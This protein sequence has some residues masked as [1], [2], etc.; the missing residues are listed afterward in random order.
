MFQPIFGSFDSYFIKITDIKNSSDLDFDNKKLKNYYT[1]S[2]IKGFLKIRCKAPLMLRHLFL[3]NKIFSNNQL[4]SGRKYYLDLNDKKSY[5]FDKNLVGK[6]L[7]IKITIFGLE[8]N[9]KIKF[10][11]NK[12]TYNLT[13]KPFELN[14]TYNNYSENLFTFE[15]IDDNI[16]NIIIAEINVGILPE[17]INKTFRH[18]DFI[19]SFGSLKIN[20]GERVI[21]KI[22]NNLTN[23]LFDF[24]IIFEG[25]ISSNSIYVDISYDKLEFQTMCE[26]S[27][28]SAPPSVPLFMVN[29]YDYVGNNLLE[30]NN[31]FFYILLNTNFV[32]STI[33]IRKP[34]L[35]SDVKFNTINF[36]P[37]L[38]GNNSKYYYQI[39]YPKPDG[40]YSFI[41]IQMQQANVI[42]AT[43]SKQNIEYS[44]LDTF[45]GYYYLNYYIIP[46]D[47]RNKNNFD[48]LNYYT[49]DPGY[50][51]F[52]QTNEKIYPNIGSTSN[53][54]VK[55]IQ[56]KDG[57]NKLMIELY[58]LSYK[59]NKN[60][61]E[62]YLLINFDSENIYDDLYSIIIGKKKPNRDDYEFMAIIEDNGVKETFSKDIKINID[63]YRTNDIF[64]IPLFKNTNYIIYD[65]II[66]SEFKYVNVPKKE[67]NKLLLYILIPIISII[68][69]I[70]AI[71]ICLRHRKKNN[72]EITVD[73]V[74]DEQ[75][76]SIEK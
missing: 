48:Y 38:T 52:I 71:F 8:V 55:N 47:K 2:K 31:K 15:E 42:R 17:N 19:D 73:K 21:I 37:E 61:V 68:I 53:K 50:I 6:D 46:L 3:L 70:I 23:D 75:L 35:Y 45:S 20:G 16:D 22:P 9:Q 64:I 29:P 62:Y 13:S 59:Y 27:Y 63:L 60:I 25:F 5:S 49:E 24:S 51:N 34:L 56:Q 76:I 10:Y 30:P 65:Y 7:Q 66:K 43:L 4:K 1:I 72:K 14:F 44:F 32:H 57:K 36:L 54:F 67:D 28:K 41:S 69:I 74:L 39:E 11:F 18:I 26:E 12:N 58:S 33:Y 40:N